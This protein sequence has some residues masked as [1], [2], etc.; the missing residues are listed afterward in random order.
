SPRRSDRTSGTC[1]SITILLRRTTQGHLRRSRR[2]NIRGA[3]CR[4]A[5]NGQDF[6]EYAS[7]FYRARVPTPVGAASDLVSFALLLRD[8][9]TAPLNSSLAQAAMPA[10]A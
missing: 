7:G 10:V 6:R 3:P 2:E 4:F 1:R 9:P 5:C 8:D